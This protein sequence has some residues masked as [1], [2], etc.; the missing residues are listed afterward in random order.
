MNKTLKTTLIFLEKLFPAVGTILIIKANI[1]LFIINQQEIQMELLWGILTTAVL[2]F[3]LFINL[4]DII[5]SL[6][7]SQNTK[8]HSKILVVVNLAFIV[9]IFFSF[10]EMVITEYFESVGAHVSIVFPFMFGLLCY[11]VKLIADS[12]SLFFTNK[13]L[14]F[15]KQFYTLLIAFY[16]VHG[17]WIVTQPDFAYINLKNRT[18]VASLLAGKLSPSETHQ[19]SFSRPA[20]ERFAV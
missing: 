5:K 8:S 4:K 2:L 19:Q 16:I 3:M 17:V 10:N 15:V 6:K 18:S 9:F 20:D 7:H 14:H 13:R 11:V 1:L 12:I